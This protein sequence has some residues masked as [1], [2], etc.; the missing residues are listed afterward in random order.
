MSEICIKSVLLDGLG[1]QH[2]FFT[3]KGG[4]SKGPYSSLNCKFDVGDLNQ[5]LERNLQ[6]V[7]D[8]LDIDLANIT[9]LKQIH[10][11][12][13][14]QADNSINQLT[15]DAVFTKRAKSAV[16]V[17][18]ADCVPILIWDDKN[19]IAMVVHAGWRGAYGGVIQ[20]AI[21]KI[22]EFKEPKIYAAIGPCI[23][24]VHYEVE[25]NFRQLFIKQNQYNEKYFV[26]SINGFP[27]KVG[28]DLT[29]RFTIKTCL[30]MES[31]EKKFL[32]NLP[33]YC[34]DILLESGVQN[35]D[36][37]GI[38]TYSNEEHF[39][40]CRRAQHKNEVSFGCQIS[41]MVAPQ[42][43]RNILVRS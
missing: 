28:A 38:D 29:T 43:V 19:K 13:V 26:S 4:Y 35:I 14:V 37:L 11:S 1:V 16:A 10:S 5:N 23:R 3:R 39:F 36:D 24:Q 31:N 32:F 17:V 22:K 30:H 34:Y 20:N 42:A 2:G 6:V 21:S 8:S 33:K 18:T 15:G 40:S 25:E 12:T 7:A 27:S 9:L 41:I